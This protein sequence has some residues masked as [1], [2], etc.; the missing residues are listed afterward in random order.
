M[1]HFGPRSMIGGTA[2]GRPL[3]YMTGHRRDG[4]TIMVET[5]E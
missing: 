4:S 3:V 1:T 2:L 5:T